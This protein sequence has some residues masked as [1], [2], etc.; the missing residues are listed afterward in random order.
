LK[1]TLI[2]VDQ[3]Q[4]SYGVLDN[5]ISNNPSDLREVK[6]YCKN[7][8]KALEK[9]KIQIPNQDEYPGFQEI[10]IPSLR[11]LRSV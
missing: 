11:H 2:A 1:A 5:V 7:E 10:H 8:L 9:G 4:K 3:T 6:K